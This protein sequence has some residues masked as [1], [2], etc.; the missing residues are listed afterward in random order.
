MAHL[1][2]MR[3]ASRP[4]RDIHYYRARNATSDLERPSSPMSAAEPTTRAAFDINAEAPKLIAEFIGTFALIFLGGG[5]I[6]VGA[7][8]V[9]VAFAHGLAIGVMVTAVGHISGGH[10]NPAVTAG[11][12]I[13][14]R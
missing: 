13:T 3:P 14:K 1:A 9:G 4:G 8:L 11:F 2:P 7:D 12:L 6:L 10:F 5:A